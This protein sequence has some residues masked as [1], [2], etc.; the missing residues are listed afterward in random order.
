MFRKLNLLIL[1]IG[2]VIAGCGSNNNGEEKIIPTDVVKNPK[3]AEGK[4]SK[5]GM[6]EIAFE[7]T[8][9]DFKEVIEG[10][11]VSYGFKFKNEGDGDLLI[12]KVY[13]SC[14]CTASEYP[15]TPIKPGEDGV[16]KISFNSSGRTGFQRKTATVLANTQPNKTHLTIKATVYRPED[17]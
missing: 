9:F 14:G 8:E 7:Q 16:V 17:L 10:E 11:Q 12:S 1:I 6:P 13:T 5:K 15:K 4:E 2:I 3:T